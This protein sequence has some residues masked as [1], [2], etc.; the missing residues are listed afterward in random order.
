MG[1]FRL[2]DNMASYFGLAALT[3]L[4]LVP[5]YCSAE[6]CLS[7]QLTSDVYTTSQTTMSSDTVIIVD[8]AVSCK[9]N[10][11][12]IN[13][14][15]EF[16][17]HVIPATQVMGQDNKYQVTHSD[18]HKNLPA[19]TYTMRFYDEE[20]YADLRKAQRSGESLDSIK[21]L[22]TIEVT[23]K[24]ASAG[25]VVQSEVVATGVALLVWYLAY[26][27]RSKIQA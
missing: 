10:L 20:G 9:N 23:H 16:L 6:T 15:A 7:P 11:K 13:L 1:P 24:G 18:E 17:G 25:P 5:Y 26:N 4:A 19:G 27:A 22:F 12:N 21:N 8:F 3:V 2:F 14:Y